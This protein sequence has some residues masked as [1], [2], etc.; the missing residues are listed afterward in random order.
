VIQ[1]GSTTCGKPYG[2]YPQDNC[3][4]TYFTIEL[5]G[6]NAQGFGDY[7]DGFSPENT[8][9][10]VGTPVPGCSVGDDFTHALGDPAV[11]AAAC[12][13]AT[14]LAQREVPALI[15]NPT[16]QSRA[17]LRRLLSRALGG[18]PVTIAAD[19]LTHSSV[20]IIERAPA[21]DAEGRRLNARAVGRPARF[22][23]IKSGERCLLVRDEGGMRWILTDTTCTA[24]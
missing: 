2:F 11:S 14:R 17:E 10:G 4:T 1:I 6:V 8:A 19:A 21:R 18:A 12:A 5:K 16:P 9:G 13:C 22:R 20:L 7:T 24:E 23:L 3:G 15:S